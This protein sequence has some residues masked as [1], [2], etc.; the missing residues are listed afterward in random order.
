MFGVSYS[1]TRMRNCC[2]CGCCRVI[3]LFVNVYSDALAMS[4]AYPSALEVTL[5]V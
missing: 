3:Y 1:D 2:C 5:T 4:C